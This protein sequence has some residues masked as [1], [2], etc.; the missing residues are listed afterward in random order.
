MSRDQKESWIGGGTLRN[1]NFSAA[2]KDL[3]ASFERPPPSFLVVSANPVFAVDG[4][5]GGS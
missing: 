2:P 3:E 4:S 1:N 5:Y